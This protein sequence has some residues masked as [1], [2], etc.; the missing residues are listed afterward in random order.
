MKDF[1]F[2]RVMLAFLLSASLVQEKIM[3]VDGL[4]IRGD[5]MVLRTPKGIDLHSP[6]IR[7]E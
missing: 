5:L 4:R 2:S 6:S 1:D 3:R 7:T